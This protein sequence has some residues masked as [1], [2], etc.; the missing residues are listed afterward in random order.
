M[1]ATT[2]EIVCWSKWSFRGWEIKMDSSRN[3]ILGQSGLSERGEVK[4]D[5]SRSPGI[6]ILI[7]SSV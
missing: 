1:L 3:C 7:M 5:S 4:M 2:V 6:L